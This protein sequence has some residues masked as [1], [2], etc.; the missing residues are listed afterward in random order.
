MQPSYSIK[1][2]M[3]RTTK[4]SGFVSVPITTDLF[5]EDGHLDAEKAMQLAV[6]MA[7]QK[8]MGWEPEGEPIVSPHPLQLPSS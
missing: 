5:R 1:F 4:E 8:S 2:R 7:E 3:Q 6:K